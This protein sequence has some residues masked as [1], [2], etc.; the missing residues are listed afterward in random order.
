M[1]KFINLILGLMVAGALHAQTIQISGQ[2]ADTA[3]H[4]QLSNAVVAVLSAD[5]MLIAFTRT[6][7]SGKF[8]LSVARKGP[9]LLLVTYPKFADYSDELTSDSGS[10]DLGKIAMIRKSA[11]LQEVIVSQ[12]IGAIRMKGDTL[13]FRADSFAVRQGANVEELLKKLPGLQ[14][15]KKGEIT[16]Q[17]EKVQKVLVDGEE[18]FSDD[19][20][21]VTQNLRA[22]AI[23]KVQ[24]F[25]KKSDQATFTGIDDGEKQKTINLQMKED[26][27]K[28]YFGKARLAGG[29]PNYFENEA[30]INLFKG[31]RK[32]AVY[33]TMA[34]TGKAGLGWQDNNKFGEGDNV[35][36]NEEDGYFYSYAEND[37]FNTWGGQFRGEG[38][39]KAWTA[40][41][42]YS[43]KWLAD[44]RNLNG[45][46]QYYK[47]D[48]ENEGTTTSQ[49]ILPDTLYFSNQKRKTF[50]LNERHQF[51]GYY[52]IKLDSLSSLKITAKGSMANA[53]N[54]SRYSG[55]SLN[56]EGQAVNSQDRDLFSSGQ[57]AQSTLSAIWRKKFAK[58]G[59]T[60]SFTLE[61]L[62]NSNQTNGQL[63]SFN[64]FFNREGINFR[65]DT[66]DQQKD[67]YLQSNVLNSRIAYTEPISKKWFLELN[68]GFRVN[69]S[70]A[71]RNSFN[72]DVNGKYKSL[73]SLYS[74]EYAFDFNTHSGGLNFRFNGA[75][76]VAAFG[77]NLSY[78]GFR[79]TDL[80]RDTTYRYNFV[81]L[82]PKASIRFK[83]GAQRGLSFNYN[84]TTRQPT[85][86]QIQPVRENTDPLNIQAGNPNLKQE[87]NHNFGMNFND[88]KVLTGRALYFNAGMNLI[89]NAIS[90]SDKVDSVGRRVYQ[91][92]NVDG[93]INYYAY[94]GI[95]FKI[96]K[97]K[98]N[99]NLGVNANGGK[100][101]NFINGFRNTNTYATLGSDFGLNYDREN[102]YSFNFSSRPSYT[103]SKSTIRPDVIT[104]YW[105]ID[106]EVNTNFQLPKKFE[107]NAS[108]AYSWRQKTDVFG[109]NR[110]V[111][112]L[113]GWLGKKFWKN[114]AGELRFS[115]NDILNQNIGFQRNAA[116][117]FIS[118]NTYQ[119]IKRYWLLSFTWNFSKNPGSK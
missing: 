61:H 69:N 34:N 107:L 52:D 59:R 20:A 28:G 38:L 14:V 13:E 82:F 58:K 75:K 40:G 83:M 16:A 57:K 87:F 79:Q 25:D 110:N 116:S 62:Y 11:L 49:Y 84:G 73:D 80:A 46:Y 36:Y 51:S 33:G 55:N 64:N 70:K 88:Y 81:N 90:G 106:N 115:M 96:K 2:V 30:M 17:G 99:V 31:K 37:E 71:L 92:V 35:E 50:S 22:D 41:A 4:K 102:K 19:P 42:H 12:K 101:N 98:L 7:A 48:V 44:K 112:L 97:L 15:N 72:K 39:P 8:R 94:S 10:L 93:N 29:L 32:M 109:Q 104:K 85:L 66:V 45:N 21:V 53:Q 24:V 23:E 78:A 119:T 6:D 76:I 67:N 1:R 77:S 54:Q 18:F 5:S 9:K 108:L 86:Q 113:G 47:Q 111:W 27:K 43:N 103:T 117:N 60:I 56:A 95:W 100:V 91:F 3:E 105:T 63:R 74:S 26:R 68:Y 89:D 65:T 118:E 114:D